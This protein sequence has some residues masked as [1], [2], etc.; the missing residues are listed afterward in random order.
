MTL[1]GRAPVI[2]RE[3]DVADSTDMRRDYADRIFFLDIGVKSV[4]QQPV[5]W[6]LNLIHDGRSRRNRIRHVTLETIQRLDGKPDIAGG[7]VLGR[8]AMNLNNA[9]YFVLR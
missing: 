9:M 6:L 5:I 4:V 8:S 1:A 3:M 2:L 7:R